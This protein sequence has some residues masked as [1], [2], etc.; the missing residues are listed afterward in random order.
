MLLSGFMSKIDWKTSQSIMKR[1]LKKA[2]QETELNKKLRHKS[3]E[4]N[5]ALEKNARKWAEVEKTNLKQYGNDTVGEFSR[6]F[7]LQLKEE[8]SK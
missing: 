6:L 2:R 4:Y 3:P 5:K 7:E 1:I 8:L